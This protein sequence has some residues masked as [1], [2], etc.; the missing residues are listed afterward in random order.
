MN[1]GEGKE[2]GKRSEGRRERIE[3]RK[4]KREEREK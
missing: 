3:R 1:G 4:G 2:K